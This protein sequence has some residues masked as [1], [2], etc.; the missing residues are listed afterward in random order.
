MLQ[1]RPNKRIF[2]ETVLIKT[3]EAADYYVENQSFPGFL[4]MLDTVNTDQSKGEVAYKGSLNKISD[5]PIPVIIPEIVHPESA[6]KPKTVD[7]IDAF[8]QLFELTFAW[9][10]LLMLS[11]VMAFLSLIHI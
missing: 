10:L 2:S 1:L 9:A 4:L 5:Q 7:L 8:Y 3:G 11:P 6:L